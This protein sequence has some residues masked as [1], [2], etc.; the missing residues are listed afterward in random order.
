MIFDNTTALDNRRLRDEFLRAVGPWPTASLD[1]RIRY[2][3]GSDFSGTCQYATN[4]LYVNLGRHL[5][6]PYR[7][8]TYLARALSSDGAWWKPQ[9]TIEL[10]DG[11]QVV[12]FVLLHEYYHWLIKRA[13][14]NIRQKESMCDRYAARVLVEQ[15]GATIHDP[16]GG[17]VPRE[18]WDFQDLERFVAPALQA[19]GHRRTHAR[20]MTSSIPR[21]S[22]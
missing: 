17:P 1:V 21:R 11:Y 16:Q 8:G 4:R 3:R 6:Y 14:R 22:P 15:Y 7:M 19:Q 13:R 5:H 18:T 10:A 2:S 20:S 12:L 9:Y